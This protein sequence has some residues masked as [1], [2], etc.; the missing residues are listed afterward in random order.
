LALRSIASRTALWVLLGSTLVL[1]ATKALLLNLTR[2][3]IL[4]RSR[5]PG[6]QCR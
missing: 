4:K 3:Q 1:A 5:L 6:G 2:T